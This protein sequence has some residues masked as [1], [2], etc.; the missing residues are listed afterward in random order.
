M[1]GRMSEW[2]SKAA[3]NQVKV[4]LCDVFMMLMLLLL[5]L[6]LFKLS[7]HQSI[8]YIFLCFL[9]VLLRG[10]FFELHTQ[11]RKTKRKNKWKNHRERE[12]IWKNVMMLVIFD[13]GVAEKCMFSLCSISRAQHSSQIL[14]EFFLYS[15][16][17]ISPSPSIV[18]RAHSH[19]V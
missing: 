4:Q 7:H 19:K 1:S 12:K 17:L 8:L 10:N 5:L 9:F 13:V 18:P 6:L 11:H 14:C 16:S 3:E 15:L 2:V